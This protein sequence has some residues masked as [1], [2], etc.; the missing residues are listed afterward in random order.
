MSPIGTSLV[1]Y[2]YSLEINSLT[3]TAKIYSRPEAS[4]TE[5]AGKPYQSGSS[6]SAY[7]VGFS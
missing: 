7:I 3:S 6:C 1:D 4:C 5:Q 2:L